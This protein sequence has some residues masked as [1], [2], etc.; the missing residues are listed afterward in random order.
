MGHVGGLAWRTTVG[1]S[2]LLVCG[3]SVTGVLLWWVKARA[4]RHRPKPAI[5]KPRPADRA[6]PA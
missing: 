5:K 1:L 6:R 3:L 4:R 2:G